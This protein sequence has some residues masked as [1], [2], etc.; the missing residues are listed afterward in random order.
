MCTAIALLCVEPLRAANVDH[1]AV[2]LRLYVSSELLHVELW[3][4]AIGP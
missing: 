2:I 1:Q 4:L 3:W